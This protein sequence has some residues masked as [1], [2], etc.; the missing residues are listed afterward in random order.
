[1]AILCPINSECM[2]NANE[3]AFGMVAMK[4]SDVSLVINLAHLS[5]LAKQGCVG[6]QNCISYV[7]MAN[8][9]ERC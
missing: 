2:G 8:I 7:M 1:M 9:F 3:S 4:L 6:E 5:L